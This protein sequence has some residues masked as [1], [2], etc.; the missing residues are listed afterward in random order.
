ME[1]A[2][3]VVARVAQG[4]LL[5]ECGWVLWT[6]VGGDRRYPVGVDFRIYAAAAARWLHGGAFYP[7]Y[8]LAGPYGIL[9]P[10]FVPPG[11]APAIMYPPVALALFVPFVFLPA[12]LWWAIPAAAV[13]LALVK[14]RPTWWAW[15]LMAALALY[16][17]VPEAV[18]NGN[19][20]IWAFAAAMLG[21]AYRWPFALV[22]VKP[23][24]APFALLG[25]ADRRWWIVLAL[26]GLAALAFLPMWVAYIHVALNMRA[27]PGYLWHDWPLLGIA[28]A[29]WLSVQW[30]SFVHGRARRA[31]RLGQEPPAAAGAN[32]PPSST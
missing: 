6:L 22:L 18:Q 29:A 3:R 14:I 26:G 30:P 2:R 1:S 25:A 28:V 20:V 9:V 31:E 13:A 21:V 17:R 32:V 27:W 23:T 16:P 24:L 12:V 19:P 7:A 5:V 15:T 10:P 8:Q 11:A 4:V